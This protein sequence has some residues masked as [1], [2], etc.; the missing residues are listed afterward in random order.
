MKH[1][2]MMGITN[3]YNV[4]TN[5]NNHILENKRWVQLIT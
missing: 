4:I 1:V 5:N 3:K 2:Y